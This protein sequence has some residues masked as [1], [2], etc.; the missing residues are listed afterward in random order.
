MPSQCDITGKQI[1]TGNNVSH[2]NRK[3]K[4]VFKPNLHKHRIFNPITGLYETFMLSRKGIKNIDKM[5]LENA[6]AFAKKLAN[7]RTG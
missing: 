5:G 6:K 1:V 7:R 4:R 3:T 2:S